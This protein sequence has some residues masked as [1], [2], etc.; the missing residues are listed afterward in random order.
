MKRKTISL[1]LCCAMITAMLFTGCE[2]PNETPAGTTEK[3]AGSTQAPA[4][5]PQTTE[6]ETEKTLE[7]VSVTIASTRHDDFAKWEDMTYIQKLEDNASD[8]LDI[9]WLD[10]PSVSVDEKRNLAINSGNYPDAMI[11]SW[12][13]NTAETSQYAGQG[14]LVPLEDYITEEL[15]PNL[16][17][18]FEKRPD[19]K[20]VLTATDGHIYA[21]PHYD[22]TS[23]L[24]RNINETMLINTKWL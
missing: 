7:K 24:V 10:W 19:Y 1:L 20:K 8:Y 13:L 17:D 11:G 18:L 6:P 9:S 5:E 23:A 16:Y 22:E 3:P 15:T 2:K 4:T 21:L 14:I 12:L